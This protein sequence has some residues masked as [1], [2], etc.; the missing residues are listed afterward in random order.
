MTELN[1]NHPPVDSTESANHA[2][3]GKEKE[4]NQRRKLREL[5]QS[6]LE[7]LADY[8]VKMDLRCSMCR[9][10]PSSPAA[11]LSQCAAEHVI[12][13]GCLDGS[14]LC[15][16][17]PADDKTALI[18]L[19]S[20]ETVLGAMMRPGQT[21]SGF[22]SEVES[23]LFCPVCLE[24]PI[25]DCLVLCPNGHGTCERCH[26]YLP[27]DDCPVCRDPYRGDYIYD[28][29]IAGLIVGYLSFGF[30]CPNTEC[31]RMFS[32]LERAQRHPER[33]TR[34]GASYSAGCCCCCC[35]CRQRERR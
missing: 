12:C 28:D 2:S 26:Y 9:Q 35:D 30:Q 34:R 6:Y 27:T 11:T 33:C 29:V 19:R 31:G 18:R 21:Y 23:T 5:H 8:I 14:G 20:V 7:S 15:P 17:C 22:R 10:P 32:S 25:E 13:G 24:L 3:S 16:R 4:E 1:A